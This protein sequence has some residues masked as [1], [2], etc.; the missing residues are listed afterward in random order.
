MTNINVIV[1]HRLVKWS[2]YYFWTENLRSVWNV[3]I[4]NR[5]KLLYFSIASFVRVYLLRQYH[6][7]LIVITFQS[8]DTFATNIT[9][10]FAFATTTIIT[11][12]SKVDD[13]TLTT[14]L[15][16]LKSLSLILL[17][18]VLLLLLLLLRL[19]PLSFLLYLL[20]LYL[21]RWGSTYKFMTAFD[22][23]VVTGWPWPLY[24]NARMLF[25]L[26]VPS[27]SSPA[28]KLLHVM[29]FLA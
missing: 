5:Y 22:I 29:K 1:Q 19:L 7:K 24:E 2:L 17:L 3:G 8:S 25:E 6:W 18:L 26:I 20:F 4:N 15:M 23:S 13:T 10:I 21:L 14:I 16:I 27:Q 12:T 28:S 11:S 9:A